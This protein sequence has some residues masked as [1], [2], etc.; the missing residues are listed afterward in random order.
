MKNLTLGPRP[1][2]KNIQ[3]LT[4]DV[5]FTLLKPEESD[6]KQIGSTTKGCHKTWAWH[7]LSTLGHSASDW[8]HWL[9]AVEELEEHL[10]SGQR[11]YLHCA[12]GI[13]RTGS[14]AYLYFRRQGST[15][16]EARQEVF[17]LRP[18]IEGQIGNK[19]AAMEAMYRKHGAGN[20][21]VTAVNR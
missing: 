20:Q 1:R 6:P 13:H 7:P 17:R 11:V 12:A 3:K 9:A 10:G 19:I 18:V 21:D 2:L 5:V 4:A 15:P 16:V 8:P 14:L